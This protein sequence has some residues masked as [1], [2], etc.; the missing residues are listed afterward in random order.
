MVVEETLPISQHGF[1]ARTVVAYASD[2]TALG[3]SDGSDEGGGSVDRRVSSF[4]H[5]RRLSLFGY[6]GTAARS[7]TQGPGCRALFAHAELSKAA[8]PPL[9]LVLRGEAS[10]QASYVMVRI[11]EEQ[12]LSG[13]GV[14]A[15]RK[16]EGM[17]IK[18][19]LYFQALSAGHAGAL[20]EKQLAVLQRRWVL[21]GHGFKDMVRLHGSGPQAH[22]AFMRGGI[23]GALF[24][25]VTA[26]DCAS[27]LGALALNELGE[28]D[29]ARAV[30]LAGLPD[31]DARLV[32]G[33]AA[34][35][36]L[37]ERLVR[38]WHAPGGV[39]ESG[40]D[41]ETLARGCAQL[42]V[43][44]RIVREFGRVLG[45]TR[46][47][48]RRVAR[49]VSGDVVVG[50]S[51][52]YSCA[53]TRAKAVR[54]YAATTVSLYRGALAK[55]L[56]GRGWPSIRVDRSAQGRASYTTAFVMR[57][58]VV[59]R[60][61]MVARRLSM[62]QK[63]Y[64]A[65]AATQ[66]VM[67]ELLCMFVL[68]V[69]LDLLLWTAIVV[70]YLLALRLSDVCLLT[71]A[72]LAFGRAHTRADIQIT[73]DSSKADGG[74][75]GF[76]VYLQHA[77][78]CP[79]EMRSAEGNAGGTAY[80]P[81]W[82]RGHTPHG[83]WCGACLLLFYLECLGV[84][85]AELDGSDAS[86]LFREAKGAFSFERGANAQAKPSSF[87]PHAL[88][89]LQYN[90][91]LRRL[92]APLNVWRVKQGL[93][94]YSKDEFHF[95][96]F[97][98]GSVMMALIFRTPKEELMRTH[99]L[100]AVTIASYAEHASA[101]YNLLLEQGSARDGNVDAAN[102]V[103]AD[104]MAVDVLRE[105]VGPH[106]W[107]VGSV[108]AELLHLLAFLKWTV[109]ALRSVHPQLRQVRRGHRTRTY[110]HELHGCVVRC[111]VQVAVSAAAYQGRFQS[112]LVAPLLAALGV[113]E[114]PAV[115]APPTA[116]ALECLVC[117]SEIASASDALPDHMA[118]A[119]ELDAEAADEDV[120][121]ELETVRGSTTDDGTATIVADD[122]PSIDDLKHMWHEVHVSLHT[123]DAA[124]VAGSDVDATEAAVSGCHDVEAS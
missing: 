116:L 93:P 102:E 11:T 22:L 1:R 118:A 29:F 47:G 14:Q 17:V 71:L 84:V 124:V 35:R 39:Y 27:L 36:P 106:S 88:R 77:R 28:S 87:A 4:Q 9:S 46:Y 41:E 52:E 40:L 119:H 101:V 80:C 30:R 72:S 7:G 64:R 67:D 103:E 13:C 81:N 21:I 19:D 110:A 96:M 113:R 95:H 55:H 51:N 60:A 76:R 42:H 15:L 69:A 104:A 94:E 70:A 62:H 122:A 109:R 79:F 54:P 56:L 63:E 31:S 107:P 86:W 49:A 45:V 74:G 85:A 33:A 65:M 91:F 34:L 38:R 66:N 50:W 5:E 98:H 8:L 114:S 58:R 92:L 97:R 90:R 53:R 20:Q 108:R 68:T 23:Q 117:E 18:W 10:Q 89:Y 48:Q 82:A 61:Y 43:P 115:A 121:G 75:E 3:D 120:A 73:L 26:G 100:D 16:R 59:L 105:V 57:R 83:R 112:Q 32:A 12:R 24:A 123:I 44:P 78:G 2:D 6:E 37:F 111:D 25:E 99:R